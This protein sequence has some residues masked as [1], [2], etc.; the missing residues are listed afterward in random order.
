MYQQEEKEVR[1]Q[2]SVP[3]WNQSKEVPFID[4]IWVWAYTRAEAEQSLIDDGYKLP[5]VFDYK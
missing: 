1:E 3:Y 2:F 5:N 4:V